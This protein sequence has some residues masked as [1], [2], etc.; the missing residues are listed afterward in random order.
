MQ[1]GFRHALEHVPSGRRSL[2]A[3]LVVTYF[4]VKQLADQC[5]FNATGNEVELHFKI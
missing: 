1:S 2:S 5:V 4:I 3:A